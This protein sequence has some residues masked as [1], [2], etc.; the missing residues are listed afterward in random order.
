MNYQ[1]TF[2]N[3]FNSHL[4]LIALAGLVFLASFSAKSEEIKVVT[5]YLPPYQIKLEDGSL[6]GYATEVISELFRITGDIPDIHIL[7]WARAYGIARREPNILVYSIAHTKVRDPL[8]HWVGPLKYERFYFWGLKSK[9]TKEY[10]S[11]DSIKGML[12]A[13]INE[14]NTE[15]YLIENGFKNI[16]K[17]VKGEQRLLMLEKQRIDIILSNELILKSL[18]HSIDYDFSKLKKLQEAKGLQS[19]LSIAFGFNTEPKLIERF[20][21]AYAELVTSG[22]LREIKHKWSIVDES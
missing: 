19:N 10:E 15:Q 22:K 21:A 18:S 20:Q 13:S 6:G 8:F 17:V 12:I 11:L 2:P 1:G 7:P 5:E 3:V 4:A 9:I 14:N 16:Y